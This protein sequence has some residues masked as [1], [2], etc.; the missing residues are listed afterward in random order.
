MRTRKIAL[1]T[2][3]ASLTAG[4]VVGPNYNKPA[5]STPP[6][7]S[8]PL[9]EGAT[10]GPAVQAQWWK[11]FKDPELDSLIARAVAANLDLKVAEARVR[12]ARAQY[13]AVKADRGPTLDLAASA[14]RT[15]ESRNQPLIG[16]LPLPPGVPFANNV[17]QAGF[18]ASWEIDVFGGTHREVEAAGA[19]LSAMDYSRQSAYI[20]LLGEV[21]RN[22][23]ELRSTQRRLAITE[24]N[25]LAQEQALAIVEGRLAHG[26]AAELD[27]D[28]ASSVL[29]STRAAVPSLESSIR[30]SVHRLGLLLAL[31]PGALSAELHNDAPIPVA[32]PEIPV[33]LPSDLI[34]RRPDIQQA[35]RE[36]AAATAMIGMAKSDWFPK[37]YLT[38]ADGYQSTGSA[39]WFTSNSS[40][41]SLGPTVQWRIF[42]AGR[43]RANIRFRDARAEQA[44]S[45]YEQTVLAS[46]EEVENALSSYANEKVRQRSLEAAATAD[47]NALAQ[48]RNLYANG[49]SPF[50]NVLDAERSLYQ[51]EDTLVQSDRAIAQ[52]LVALYKALGG[53]WSQGK[54]G[55]S[56]SA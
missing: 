17:Y 25:I 44:L 29:S 27:R 7:W 50:L 12:E 33:G 23:I 22:Y 26:L 52:D 54:E 48:S 39:E 34:L 43:I 1:I 36:L 55:A 11:T 5:V 49:L 6:K 30:L 4:C 2:V 45:R 19:Q 18:D 8:E 31:P 28:Q 51:A 3:A 14:D 16:A 15:L 41:W 46:F 47:R 9:A 24:E 53:G 20:S 10:S 35:E 21:A 38:G 40:F 37:F 42:D 56:P 32:P 13:G